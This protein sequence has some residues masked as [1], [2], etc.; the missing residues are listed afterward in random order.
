VYNSLR[1]ERAERKRLEAQVLQLQHDL[2]DLAT[3]IGQ[4]LGIATTSAM[5]YPTPSPDALLM[6]HMTR[7]GGGGGGGLGAGPPGTGPVKGGT[8]A[9]DELVGGG[10]SGV[11]GAGSAG[12]S[13]A[14]GDEMGEYGLGRGSPGE[15]AREAREAREVGVGVGD[16]WQGEMF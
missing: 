9:V 16:D 2:L 12:G 10:S 15:W 3:I 11:G 4:Q 5:A 13:M 14:S 1:Y 6:A 8:G 7:S